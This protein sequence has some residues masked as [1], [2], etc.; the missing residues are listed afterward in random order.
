MNKK[1]GIVL[2]I[3]LV[4]TLGFTAL[5]IL[6]DPVLPPS[7]MVSWWPGDGD[8][9]DIQGSNDGVLVDDTDYVDPGKVVQA[10]DFDGDGDAVKFGDILEDVFSGA[11]KHFTI[12]F[13]LQAD[14]LPSGVAGETVRMDLFAK[15]GDSVVGPENQRQ[16]SL[17]LRPDGSVDFAFYGALNGSSLRIIR[18]GTKLT[19]G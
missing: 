10:F 6:A 13:W 5:P 12:D 18:S 15:L 16:L 7:G 14:A 1:L 9:T 11:D 17:I 8:T 3:A 19:T 4:L 2:S